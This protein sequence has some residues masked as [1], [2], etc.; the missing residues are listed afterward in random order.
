MT[1]TLHAL[2]IAAVALAK[3][4]ADREA[5]V[6]ADGMIVYA[7]ARNAVLD[8]AL[9]RGRELM[10]EKA[11]GALTPEEAIDKA[12]SLLHRCLVKDC[13]QPKTADGIGYCEAHRFPESRTE[14]K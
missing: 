14:S 3:A 1:A 12:R 8:A 10:G 5:N 4:T 9:A 7:K 11:D 6:S 2:D 13:N